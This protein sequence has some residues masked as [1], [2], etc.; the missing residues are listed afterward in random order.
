MLS[1][2]NSVISPY[3]D[4][5]IAKLIVRGSDREEARKRMLRCLDEFVIEGIKTSIP[6]FKKILTSDRFINNNYDTNFIDK[7]FL[8]KP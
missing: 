5:M 6:F 8:G 2:C 1:S 3:Y 7:E 4:S